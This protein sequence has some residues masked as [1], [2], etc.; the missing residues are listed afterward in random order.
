MSDPI[1]IIANDGGGSNLWSIVAIG[2][3]VITGG[4]SVWWSFRAEKRGYLDNFW[5]REVTAPACIQPALDMRKEWVERI[6]RLGNTQLTKDEYQHLIGDLETA[7]NTAINKAW[8]SKIFKGALFDGVSGQYEAVLD[9]VAR[10]LQK[11]VDSPHV[12]PVVT[13]VDL[14]VEVSTLL[15]GVLARAAKANSSRLE[16]A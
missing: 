9:K 5:F 16:L 1:N 6:E 8:V 13:A 14:S 4:F 7:I 11:H 12:V 15:M 10:G 2:I 3:S